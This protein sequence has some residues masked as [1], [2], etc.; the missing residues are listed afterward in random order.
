MPAG[1]AILLEAA[2]AEQLLSGKR[3][4]KLHDIESHDRRWR[5]SYRCFSFL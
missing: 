2:S 4:K 5:E 3:M 1:I